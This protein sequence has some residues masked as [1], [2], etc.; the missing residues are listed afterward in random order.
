M[1]RNLAMCMNTFLLLLTVAVAQ[2][3]ADPPPG[4]IWIGAEQWSKLPLAGPAWKQLKTQADQPVGIPNLRDQ[5]QMNNV[6]VLTKALVYARTG[7]EKYRTE[8][9]QQLKLA[10]DTELDGRTLALG[11]ELAVYVIAADL[12]NLPRY[13]ATFD[14]QEFRPWL[15][16]T[17]TETLEGRTLQ[18]THEG[19]PNNWGTHAGASR[20]AVAVYLGDTVELARTAQVFQGYLGDRSAYASFQFGTDLSWQCGAARPVGINPRGCRKNGHSLDGVLPDD[21]RRCGPFQWPPCRTNQD[22]PRG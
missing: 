22:T 6:Y 9:R 13:D 15:R 10:M 14:T 18:S 2:A 3:L 8:V 16:R 1:S 4:T 5:D 11:R 17:L 12:I 20:A 21:Q 19:R 7:E